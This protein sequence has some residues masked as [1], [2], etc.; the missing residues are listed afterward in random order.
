M[1]LSYSEHLIQEG[2]NVPAQGEKFLQATLKLKGFFVGK[3]LTHKKMAEILEKFLA[4]KFDVDVGWKKSSKLD[5]THIVFNGFFDPEEAASGDTAIELEV[6]G[7]TKN[8]TLAMSDEGYDLFAKNLAGTYTHEMVHFEQYRRRG[9]TKAKE[10]TRYKSPI[11]KVQKA[12]NYLG[13][14]DE[15][16]A[17]AFNIAEQLRRNVS[18]KEA[19][20]ILRKP[21]K[22]IMKTSVDLFAYAAAF[23]FDFTH[24]IL[25]RL[26]KK[27]VGFLA[28]MK[29]K[30]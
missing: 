22:N 18:H 21:T 17:F 1:M 24:P 28:Q 16:E 20:D 30:E 2:I 27:T 26:L 23:G 10:L 12:Q 13:N 7:S 19:L 25:K 8:K 29:D 5:D 4:P 9:F 3:E 11:A 6:V 15:V 14:K